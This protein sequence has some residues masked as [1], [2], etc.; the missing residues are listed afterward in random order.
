MNKEYHIAVRKVESDLW[1]TFSVSTY[2]HIS[3]RF[4]TK[5]REKRWHLIQD[6]LHKVLNPIVVM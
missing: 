1:Q 4:P 2:V 6:Q 5:L 3:K